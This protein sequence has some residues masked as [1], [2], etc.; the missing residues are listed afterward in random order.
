MHHL[1]LWAQG[2]VG[3]AGEAAALVDVLGQRARY[4]ILRKKC[5]YN[6]YSIV[7]LL[8]HAHT[9]TYTYI[10]MHRPHKGLSCT[11][12]DSIPIELAI[13]PSFLSDSLRLLDVSKTVEGTQSI[14][15]S[16]Y[17]SRNSSNYIIILYA[18]CLTVYIDF[19]TH[20]S[21]LAQPLH[22]QVGSPFGMT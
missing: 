21:V 19:Y 11:D 14:E 15:F 2:D 18:N 6:N 4:N 5:G 10:H 1:P 12:G 13:A 7:K 17:C 22:L 8:I 16:I 3:K 20:M 9:H